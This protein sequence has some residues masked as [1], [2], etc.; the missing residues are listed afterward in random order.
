MQSEQAV[1]P[2]STVPEQKYRYH[3]LQP[4]CNNEP[5]IRLL[6]LY[7]GYS[8]DD[9][10]CSLRTTSLAN[11]PEFEALSYVWGDA[12]HKFPITCDGECLE[13]TANLLE[14]LYECRDPD[15]PR[16]LWIDALCIDQS[17]NTEKEQ[18][19]QLMRR[20]YES[21]RRVLV[22]LGPTDDDVEGMRLIPLLLAA[23]EHQTAQGDERRFWEL[24]PT[25]QAE[26]GLPD[27]LDP[28]YGALGR[29][30]QRPWFSRVWIIQE[31]AVSRDAVVICGMHHFSWTNFLTAVEYSYKLLVPAYWSNTSHV[32]RVMQ[33]E[34][35][36]RASQ[37]GE[38]FSLS[39]L[40]HLFRKFE[41]TLLK[42]KIYALWGL[43]NDSGPE[44][45]DIR[46]D[47]GVGDAELYRVV[48]LKI[49][50]RQRH[51]DLLSVPRADGD[52]KL[53]ALP[54]WVP[55]WSIGDFGGSLRMPGS[56]GE[57]LWDFEATPKDG[58]K[59]LEISEDGMA[60]GLSGHV[61]D[62]VIEV[63]E[64]HSHH[65]EGDL[66]MFGRLARI[67]KEQAVLNRWEKIGK[68]R[69]GNEYFATGEDL[70]DVYWQILIAG[71]TTDGHAT[72]RDEFHRW[73]G[74][75]SL[76]RPGWQQLRA[77]GSLISKLPRLYSN[78]ST[79]GDEVAKIMR[80][81]ERMTAAT[82]RRFFRTE[83]GY[84]GIGPQLLR[85]GDKIV[86]VKG[87]MVPLVLRLPVA[88]ARWELI[89]DAYVH[90]VMT[91]AAF[92]VDRCETVWIR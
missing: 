81:R 24:G 3:P 38:R 75:R 90:G 83:A 74:V 82:N 63:G 11:A 58:E 85:K 7:T 78:M 28:A 72:I 47:Y 77:W 54:S 41:A 49:L 9:V 46:I 84:L 51:L 29:L 70:L 62:T 27:A 45:L 43:A 87:G 18:Q 13:V 68:S 37:S 50:R 26:Y 31:L 4:D 52:S 19:V 22:F 20:I 55:D 48:C 71:Q 89:G 53:T 36:R 17:N 66:S 5:Q 34:M 59:V 76:F 80:F 16:T 39:T 14:A 57:A 30:L 69:S 60:I 42:D 88:Q 33:I 65:T 79:A 86:L 2:Q 1:D 8:D 25:G 23:K 64:I 10:H 92:D 12:S 21:A 40:L 91:G 32:E 56:T 61:L 15:E 67:P 35:A 44:E 6:T 73:D